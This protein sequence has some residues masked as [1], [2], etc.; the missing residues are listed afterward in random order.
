L[1]RQRPALRAVKGWWELVVWRRVACGGREAPLLVPRRQDAA[2][3]PSP[4]GASPPHHARA[5]ILPPACALRPPH[6][7]RGLG[8]HALAGTL[9]P[10]RHG[11]ALLPRVPGHRTRRES[12]PRALRPL[13]C[14]G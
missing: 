5:A 10:S 13:A 8:L 2:L 4:S 6:A 7:P 1:R 14:A 12:A 11:C 9:P 3:L